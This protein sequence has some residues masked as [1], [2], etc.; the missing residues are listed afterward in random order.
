ME[1]ATAVSVGNLIVAAVGVTATVLFG[2]WQMF[3]SAQK[4]SET[5]Q[6]NAKEDND[7]AHGELGRK[8]DGVKEG[9]Q[10]LT[11]SMTEVKKD[12]E[13]LRKDVDW[14]VRPGGP[15]PAA[16]RTEAAGPAGLTERGE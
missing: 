6:R 13:Y 8:I 11:V 3:R 4:S 5:A 14:Y 7:K 15:G 12:V 2:V 10:T 1:G 16:G 9:V